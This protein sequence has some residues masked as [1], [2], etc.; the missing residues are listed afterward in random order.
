MIQIFCVVCMAPHIRPHSV[1]CKFCFNKIFPSDFKLKMRS[2][3]GIPH[4]YLFEWNKKS[5]LACRSLIYFYKNKPTVFF[6]DSAFLFEVLKDVLSEGPGIVPSCSEEFKINHAQSFGE[7]LVK[8]KMISRVLVAGSSEGVRLRQQKK[9]TRFE[10]LKSNKV[11]VEM[12]RCVKR[13]IFVDDVLVSG[14]T[15]KSIFESMFT[16][17]QAVFT[18]FYKPRLQNKGFYDA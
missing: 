9:K 11:D 18:L 10:R 12:F 1:L 15:F 7:A 13:W 2:E 14:G 8:Q 6:E 17:P 16:K 5:D 3:Q 4:Y